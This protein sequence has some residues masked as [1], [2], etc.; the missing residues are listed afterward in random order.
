M[1]AGS[2]GA[3]GRLKARS[4]LGWLPGVALTV[5][6]L[7]FLAYAVDWR[8][9][10]RVIAAFP[11]G[12]L[13]TATA[14]YLV[15]MVARALCWHTLL[16]RRA[17]ILTTIVVMNEGYFLN[18]ILPARVGELGRAFLMGRRSG[19]GTFWVLSTIVVER[20]YDV[21]FAAALLLLTLPLVLKME[22]ARP[23]ASLLLAAI[24]A[25][26]LVVYLAARNRAWLEGRLERWAG[27]RAFLQRWVLPRVKSLLDGFAVLARPEF[28]F[29]SLLWMA[30]TWGLAMLRDWLVL[31]TLMPATPFWW[32]VLAISA[33]NL[34]GALP[35]TMASIGVFEGAAVAALSLV[36][37]PAEMALAYALIVH[38]THLISSSLIGA[39]GMS[40]EGKSLAELVAELRSAKSA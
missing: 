4:V 17:G 38:I 16:Q 34:G 8:E 13:A 31:Y 12:A 14:L 22:Q 26:L 32:A 6:A 10:L 20:A 24:V 15:S 21:A 11:V 3:A 40:Q 7:A 39:Y 18:N 37:F 36:G 29:L 28:F 27:R 1:R 30:S 25:G 19:L 23:L 2:P 35:S 33:A 5:A 9:F